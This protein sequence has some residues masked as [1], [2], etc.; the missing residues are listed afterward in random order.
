MFALPSAARYR[1]RDLGCQAARRST[2]PRT[3][4]TGAIQ[5][6]WGVSAGLQPGAIPTPTASVPHDVVPRKRYSW[7]QRHSNSP[8]WNPRTRTNCWRSPRRSASRPAPG[9]RSP[10]S[11]TRSWSPP[12]RRRAPSNGDGRAGRR[13]RR[14]VNGSTSNGDR[15]GDAEAGHDGRRAVEVESPAVEP[16]RRRST[17]A[18]RPRSVEV[19]EPP[20][21]WEL[22]VGDDGDDDGDDDADDGRRRRSRQRAVGRPRPRPRRSAPAAARPARRQGRQPERSGWRGPAAGRRVRRAGQRVPAGR[23]G[24]RVDD[25]ESRNRRRRRRRKGG[26]R[27]L[28][29]PQGDDDGA[30]RRGRRRRRP[31]RRVGRAGRRVGLPRH[32]RRGLRLPPRRRATCRAA[33]TP[34]SRSSWPASTACA[35]ATTSPGSAG[36]PA[37]TRRTRRCSRSTPSTAAIPRRPAGGP[38][39]RTS[40]R[41]S[42]TSGCASRTRPTRRT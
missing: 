29:G 9:R 14:V 36:R 27:G 37:A 1:G 19:D 10:T 4:C 21:E 34:T 12:V 15:A 17:W 38:G 25:G 23:V 41:C 2:F 42:P 39:S 33:T 28:D 7:P 24:Q 35:R 13:R 8:S 11:S 26:A 5:V 18:R 20:A 32:A 40:R 6:S 16:P 30:A 3:C 22:A 31:R